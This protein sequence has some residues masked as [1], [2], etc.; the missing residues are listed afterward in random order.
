MKIRTFIWN[1]E[2]THWYESGLELAI[3][4]SDACPT[5]LQRLHFLDSLFLNSYR[6][7]CNK[8]QRKDEIIRNHHK[9]YY[10]HPSCATAIIA[11]H[12]SSLFVRPTVLSLPVTRAARVTPV[13]LKAR[14]L[15]VSA[16]MSY[17]LNLQ[18]YSE[19]FEIT[20]SL[21]SS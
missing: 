15:T 1:L 9:S 21:S 7:A 14:G 11:I 12:N 8:I 16:V 13:N 19:P 6:T 3:Q 4:T 10:L 20:R 2:K 5:K 18:G 17:I